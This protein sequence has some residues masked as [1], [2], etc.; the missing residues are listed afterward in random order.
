MPRARGDRVLR[1][2]YGHGALSRGLLCG[3]QGQPELLLLPAGAAARPGKEMS[4]RCLGYKIIWLRYHLL[5]AGFT[6]LVVVESL[7]SSREDDTRSWG[8]FLVYFSHKLTQ[9]HAN[10]RG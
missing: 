10:L 4:K 6:L 3:E 5:V 2:S 8:N 1:L 9:Y 7:L